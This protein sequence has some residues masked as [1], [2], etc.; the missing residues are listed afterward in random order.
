MKT[1]TR[2]LNLTFVLMLTQSYPIH[3]PAFADP[4]VK[5]KAEGTIHYLKSSR[6]ET[7]AVDQNYAVNEPML[8]ITREKIPLLVLSAADAQL[9]EV[10][11]PDFRQILPKSYR[12]QFTR[13]LDEVLLEVSSVQKNIREGQADDALR[14]IEALQVSIPDLAF[15]KFLKASVQVLL[16]STGRSATFWPRRRSRLILISKRERFSWSNSKLQLNGGP[17]HDH[18]AAGNHFF[19]HLHLR[20]DSLRARN[21]GATPFSV[22]RRW[23]H[24]RRYARNFPDFQSPANHAQSLGRTPG[25]RTSGLSVP[26]SSR[27]PEQ[28]RPK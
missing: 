15:L 22:A 2:F 24:R 25:L 21:F 18:A 4:A 20:R 5:I 11:P 7:I 13:A 19:F 14:R 26:P 10:R 3:S 6:E 16:V 1:K 27:Y 8:I 28:A 17:P 9:T 12:S 23:A